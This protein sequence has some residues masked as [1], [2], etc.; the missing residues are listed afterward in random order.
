MLFVQ[1]E[2]VV[3]YTELNTLFTSTNTHACYSQCSIRHEANTFRASLVFHFLRLSSIYSHQFNTSPALANGTH[4]SI[5]FS[6]SLPLNC[7][8]APLTER[9]RTLSSHPLSRH[10][11]LSTP[12]WQVQSRQTFL[13][14]SSTSSSALAAPSVDPP[15]HQE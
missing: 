4:D 15:A 12:Q 5:C 3:R 6:P 2:L 8:S 9:L 14:L 11:C 10:C 1:K 13:S 7:T